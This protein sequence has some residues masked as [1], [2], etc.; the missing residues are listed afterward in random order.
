MEGHTHSDKYA[1]QKPTLENLNTEI[2]RYNEIRNK[3]KKS[4]KKTIVKA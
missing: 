3:I 1:Y 4:K 2:N